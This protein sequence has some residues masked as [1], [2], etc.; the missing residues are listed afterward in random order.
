MIMMMKMKMMIMMRILMMLTIIIN[1]ACNNGVSKE[2][3]FKIVNIGN[4]NDDQDCEI[5]CNKIRW[6]KI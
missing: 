6:F 4:N 1:Y 5:K 3:H 2:V